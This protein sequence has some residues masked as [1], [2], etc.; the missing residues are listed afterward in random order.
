M[1][2]VIAV[3]AFNCADPIKAL[4]KFTGILV[5]FPWFLRHYIAIYKTCFVTS[6]AFQ[7][8]QWLT[9]ILVLL[10]STSQAENESAYRRNI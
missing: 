2:Q 1:C 5:W 10:S 9:W 3:L 8:S 4:T 7:L 6:L